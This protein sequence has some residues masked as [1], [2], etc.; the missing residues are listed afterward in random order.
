[1]EG[2]RDLKNHLEERAVN[3][4]G[5]IGVN[6]PFRTILSHH[7]AHCT[8][9]GCQI[10]QGEGMV[11]LNLLIPAD[12]PPGVD[13]EMSRLIALGTHEDKDLPRR[14]TETRNGL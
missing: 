8:M 9:K 12:R 1:M 11:H 2:N 5:R 6:G 7:V 3:L 13:W 10:W 14:P 4:S